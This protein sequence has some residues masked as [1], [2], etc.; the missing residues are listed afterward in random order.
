[1]D[2]SS[3]KTEEVSVYSKGLKVK[4]WS[5][6]LL[7]FIW[8]AVFAAA[9]AA[10]GGHRDDKKTS[11]NNPVS[12]EG[13]WKTEGYGLVLQGLGGKITFYQTTSISGMKAVEGS[14]A[15]D[16]IT[17]PVLNTTL[18]ATRLD[19]DRLLLKDADETMRYVLRPLATL[20]TVLRNGGTKES[21]DPILNF[22]VFWQAFEENYGFFKVRGADWKVVRDRYRPQVNANT[23][24]DE[25]FEI[26]SNALSGLSS[27][28]H[29]RLVDPSHDK[30][31][32][33][34]YDEDT[35]YAMQGLVL[36]DPTFNK[37]GKDDFFAYKHLNAD[38]TLI[39]VLNDMGTDTSG[40]KD[41]EIKQ[42]E[43]ILAACAGK[44]NIILDLRANIGGIDTVSLRIAGHFAIAKHLAF[45]K[46]ARDGDGFAPLYQ[47]YVEPAGKVFQ[48]KVY[49]LT[50]HFTVSAGET[51]TMALRALPNVTVIGENT[52]GSLSDM[53]MHSLPNGWYVTLSNER[54]IAAD[55]GAYEKTGV[56]PAIYIPFDAKAYLA[57]N[58]AT[59][60]KALELTGAR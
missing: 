12:L 50:S 56:P 6:R 55:G 40:D 14:Y 19:G 57:G 37:T 26:M 21:S 16:T 45:S 52:N 20:P 22:D 42:L 39:S 29:T 35:V 53:L 7:R 10:C 43:T 31:S 18:K 51:L 41:G 11:N 44:K 54:Y 3:W 24:P 9:L 2:S 5:N 47:R 36:N 27:D 1:M 58:D 60:S 32:K 15:G 8:L 49:V 13:V 38:T 33:R 23:T 59:L 25:L 30:Y 46:Q 4:I 28:T 17:I 48:G 34:D